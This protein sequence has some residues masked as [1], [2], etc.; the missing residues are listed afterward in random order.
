MKYVTIIQ[1]VMLS[2]FYFPLIISL[3]EARKEC[4]VLWVIIFIIL[5]IMILSFQ[6]VV[7]YALIMG[8]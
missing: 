8:Y 4:N 6:M 3:K 1:A 7:I 5:N 2:C